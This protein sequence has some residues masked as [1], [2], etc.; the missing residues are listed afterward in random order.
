EPAIRHRPWRRRRRRAASVFTSIIVLYFVTS[1]MILP[2]AWQRAMARH[3]AVEGVPRCTCTVAGIPGDPLNLCFIAKEDELT[4][5]MLKAG[6]YPADPRTFKT[7]VR[8]SWATLLHR[9]Y[10][11]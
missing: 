4:E 1:Y 9:P 8:I 10:K 6:W 5:A 3:P 7:S 2:A 11:E